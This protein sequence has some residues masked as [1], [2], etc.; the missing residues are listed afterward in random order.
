[1]FFE[2]RQD[3]R[4]EALGAVEQHEVDLARQVASESLQGAALAQLDE[5]GQSA[6]G[7]VLL[8]PCCL[9]RFE[10]GGDDPAAAVVPESGCEMQRRDAERGAELDNGARA[11]RCC[12]R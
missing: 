1:V 6:D 4:I 10:L 9:G 11:G 5:I 7:E 3:C 8:R 2:K 12:S